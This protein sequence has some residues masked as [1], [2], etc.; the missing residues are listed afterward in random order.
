MRVARNLRGSR[1][2]TIAELQ[3]IIRRVKEGQ[4]G[5]DHSISQEISLA[6][7]EIEDEMFHEAAPILSMGNKQIIQHQWVSLKM[8]FGGG[9]AATPLYRNAVNRWFEQVSHFTP[10]VRPIPLPADLQ[11]PADI[12]ES[13]RGRLFRR[14]SVAYGLSFDRANLDDHRFPRDMLP[15]PTQPQVQ[16]YRREAPT[17]DE[18]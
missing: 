16:T 8:I 2:Q 17:K 9:G 12:S 15:L 4:G 13:Q 5:H 6:E 11:W 7:R 10:E 18:C 1:P 3:D 14:F